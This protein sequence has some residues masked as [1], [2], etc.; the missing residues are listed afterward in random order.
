MSARPLTEA[1]VRLVRDEP[2]TA[3]GEIARGQEAE[4]TGR[5]V[6]ARAHYE[7][8]LS[9]LRGDAGDTITAAMLMRRIAF[10]HQVDLDLDAAEDCATAAL[11]VSEASADDAGV[12]HATNIL[13]IVQWRRGNIEEA[14]RLYIAA[15]ASARRCGDVTLAAMTSQNLG[16]LASMGGDLRAALRFY[17]SSL[18]DYRALG[19][20]NEMMRAL[21]NLGLL[22][23]DLE[24]WDAAQRSY[25]E[26]VEIGTLSGDLSALITVHLN[27]A[28]MWIARQDVGR[29]AEAAAKADQ[30]A[31]TLDDHHADGERARIA[32]ILARERDA[33]A[34]AEQSFRVAIDFAVRHADLSLEADGAR[35]LAELYRRQGRNR[36]ALQYLARAH[37][38]FSQLRSRREV[39]DVERRN[40]RLEAEFLSVVQ[41]WGESIEAKDLYTQGHCE[42]V[43]E[44]AC[45]LAIRAGLPREAMFW[46]RIGAVLH[47]VGKLVVPSEILNKPG[48]LSP[49][50]WEVIHTHPAAGVSLLSQVEFPGDVLPIVR[51][52]HERWSGGGYPDGLSGEAIP[53]SAR[54][55]CIADVYDALTS[56]RS[57]QMPYTHLEAMEIMRRDAGRRFDPALFEL[58]EA[59]MQDGGRARTDAARRTPARSHSALPAMEE[60]DD[61]TGVMTRRS[62]IDV[63]ASALASRSAAGPGAMLVLDVDLFKRVNDA[64]GHLR[65]DEVLQAVAAVLRLHL[66][67]VGAVGRFAGDEFVAWLPH[68]DAIE[69]ERVAEAIRAAVQ[70]RRVPATESAPSLGVTVS[71]GVACV[72]TAGRS[73]EELFAAADRAMYDAKRA[74]RNRVGTAT[75]EHARQEPTLTSERFVGRGRELEQLAM[76]LDETLRRRPQLLLLS[77]DAGVGKTTL[78]RQ[79][80]T[81]VR[82]RGGV[83]VSGQCFESDLRP[84]YSPWIEALS[85]LAS[86]ETVPARAWTELPRLVPSLGSP[87]AEAPPSKYALYEEVTEFLR[88]ASAA[89]PLTL[90]LEDMQWADSA[91]W[92]LLEHVRSRLTTERMLICL[93]VRDEPARALDDERR[94]RLS[95]DERLR[96]VHLGPLSPAEIRIW[97][98]SVL[99]RRD[100]SPELLSAVNAR[101]EGNPLLV[102][103]L[104]RAMRDGHAL[105]HDGTRWQW[106]LPMDVSLPSSSLDLFARRIGRLTPLSRRILSVAAVIG[107]RFD[108]D[109]LM[110]AGDWDEDDVLEA[111]D[112]GLDAGVIALVDEA[113][114]EEYSFCHGL[115]R[116]AL[117]RS[118]NPRREQR[119]HERI[120]EALER[121]N[122]GA[123]AQLAEHYDRAGNDERAYEHALKAGEAAADVH[124]TEDAIAFFQTASRHARTADERLRAFR[125]VIRLT[126]RTGAHQRC[127]AYCDG[128]LTE[129]GEQ[130]RPEERLW[131]QVQ[132]ARVR[133]QT[134]TTPTETLRICADLI[135]DA[136]RLGR[137]DDRVALA[138]LQS[139]AFARCGDATAAE[140]AAAEAVARADA[141]G[142]EALHTTSLL[143][144]GTMLLDRDPSEALTLFRRALSRAECLG[145]AYAEARCRVAVGVACARLQLD[146]AAQTAYET[147]ASL[148]QRIHA[149]ELAGLAA[150]N[151]GVLRLHSGQ[152]GEA[153]E[154]L[155]AA[156]SLFAVVHNEPNRL[157]ALYNA[158]SVEREI[159]NASAAA[160]LYRRTRDLATSLG[161]RDV[162]LGAAAGEGLSALRLGQRDRATAQAE[163]LRV[164]MAVEGDRW[165]QGREM[166]DALAVR[167]AIESGCFDAAE[168]TFWRAL[169]LAERHDQYGAAWFVAEVVTD[170]VDGGCRSAWRAAERFA[171][172]VAKLGYASLS[173]RYMVLRDL[174]LRDPSLAAMTGAA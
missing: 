59:L 151:L 73:F 70:Q 124:A 100:L 136:D 102:N 120:A 125:A 95:R 131:L 66:D 39:A 1:H 88:L 40:A 61:L 145:D 174:A 76:M 93:T 57:Y 43:S 157:V 47:D 83:F 162:A 72:A 8:A 144:L 30:I 114:R 105:W 101:T 42:R 150:L 46:F 24:R 86:S 169:G 152:L 60:A 10:T 117:R 170:L 97:L 20:S 89:Q 31:T 134:G 44:L 71:I 27:V 51:S 37:R 68:A 15:R 92:D 148:A 34:E 118:Q 74:G 158:A 99:D 172:T 173:A 41:K 45:A 77:G 126:D 3:A 143:R 13:A 154:Q 171:P 103:Q 49:A 18:A 149:P 156:V 142:N 65:G 132:R 107:R 87:G 116:D 155:A 21:N 84:P 58:F 36:E 121:R 14:E 147:A 91:A 16:V 127:E 166:I 133:F 94:I 7:S 163:W 64:F 140:N 5:R 146:D 48:P 106:R 113:E 19:L 25:A 28:G 2:S 67:E 79:L 82:L 129:L 153:R 130:L 55:V 138:I 123:A 62:F 80:G 75:Q 122:P 109:L 90:V 165:F 81:D 96:A 22:Y 63:V 137:D 119:V 78:L 17:H 29:A 6:E 52:H 164:E 98:E 9:L 32:G 168:A 110:S 139:H 50:E 53:L 26:A 23:T 108:V 141:S 12:G 104:L 159:G 128:A 4:R 33:N 112:D 85:T 69:A 38:L 135:A 35:E 115:V 111:V 56:E 167:I 160:E 54:I 161:H 11:A